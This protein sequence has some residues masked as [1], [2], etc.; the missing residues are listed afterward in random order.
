MAKTPKEPKVVVEEKSQ[1]IPSVELNPTISDKGWTEWILSQLEE[2]EKI[3]GYPTYHGL[4]RMFEKYIGYIHNV[5]MDVKQVADVNNL[6]RATVLV[7]IEYEDEF[8]I[9][10]SISDVAD[11]SEG[12]TK[13]PYNLYPTATA[14]TMAE[15]RAMRKALRLRTIAAEESQRDEISNAVNSIATSNVKI[16]DVQKNTINNLCNRLGISVAKLL[17]SMSYDKNLETLSHENAQSVLRKLNL[18]ERGAD[19]EGEIIPEALF[20]D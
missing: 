7:T 10:H 2:N 19:N 3:E 8:T 4:R 1:Q 9:K 5:R 15:S 20:K 13:Y 14:A 16:T 12:N 18:Y 6:N 11:V 17:I